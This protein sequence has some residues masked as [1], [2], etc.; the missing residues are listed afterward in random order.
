VSND[1]KPEP[2]LKV[3]TV[4]RSTIGCNED[5]AIQEAAIATT[6]AEPCDHEWEVID[7][8]FDHEYGREVIVFRQCLT[9]GEEADYDPPRFDDDVL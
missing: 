8:S 9:C 5:N 7:Q 4:S 2:E 1:L 3:F 6:A